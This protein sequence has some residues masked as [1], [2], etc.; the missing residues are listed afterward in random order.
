MLGTKIAMTG[1]PA[2]RD[3]ENICAL[4]DGDRHLG[5]VVYTGEWEAFDGT[6]PN[7][8]GNGFRRLG[9]FPAI[10]IAKA[11]VE[12][13]VCQSAEVLAKSAVSGAWIS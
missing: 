5:H 8:T 13:A 12:R 4:A 7:D 11:A 6:H 2:W 9:A 3:G 1:M 10:S